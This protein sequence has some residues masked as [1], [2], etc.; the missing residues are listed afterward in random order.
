MMMKLLALILMAGFAHAQGPRVARELDPNTEG[1]SIG[2]LSQVP[3]RRT[4]D[5]TTPF[6]GSQTKVAA[7]PAVALFHEKVWRK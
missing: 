7:P 1:L 4:S 5:G 3:A 6:I 2:F